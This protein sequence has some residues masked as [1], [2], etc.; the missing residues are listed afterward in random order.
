MYLKCKRK[1]KSEM[2][3]GNFESFLDIGTYIFIL[4][5]YWLQNTP[6]QI[7]K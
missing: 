6:C 7:Q 5:I 3:K 2:V 4:G 1:Y